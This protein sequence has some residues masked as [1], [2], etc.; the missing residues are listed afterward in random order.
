MLML[1]SLQYHIYLDKTL[2]TNPL[3]NVYF[4]K[5]YDI[6]GQFSVLRKL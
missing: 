3:E 5:K 2:P 4:I 1:Q 6:F